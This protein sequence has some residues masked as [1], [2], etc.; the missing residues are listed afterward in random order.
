MSN[1]S[2][3]E[4][5]QLPL[6][7]FGQPADRKFPIL[8]QSD[9]DGAKHLIGNAHDPARC[10]RRII[11]I[12]RRH[13]WTV[14]KEWEDQ[15]EHA[16]MGKSA[17]NL[18]EA[19]EQLEQEIQD[20][21]DE[22]IGNILQKAL[23]AFQRRGLRKGAVPAKS[24]VAAKVPRS[25]KH[26]SIGDNPADDEDEITE[27]GDAGGVSEE[28]IQN[29]HELD[30]GD[31]KRV[32]AARTRG[33]GG[34]KALPDSLPV[35]RAKSMA[36]DNTAYNERVADDDE[37]YDDDDE[38]DEEEHEAPKKIKK[39]IAPPPAGQAPPPPPPP[40]V[41]ADPEAEEEEEDP[42]ADEDGSGEEEE[43]PTDGEAAAAMA[44]MAK[45]GRVARKSQG[46]ETFRAAVDEFPGIEDYLDASDVLQHVVKSLT[47]ALRVM[48]Q[49][50]ERRL[51]DL[52]QGVAKSLQD[53]L[54]KALDAGLEPFAAAQSALL[55]SQQY[56]V[57]ALAAAP[58]PVAQQPM[59]G[60]YWNPLVAAQL[61]PAAAKT[62]PDAV[63]GISKDEMN[64]RL[65]KAMRENNQEAVNLLGR[66]DRLGPDGVF[67][68]MS[69]G[70]KTALK[71][72]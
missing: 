70:L 16:T 53:Q 67:G 61:T 27:L 10:K 34:E 69:D 4:R 64:A 42:N 30:A 45:K 32:T 54:T 35:K 36:K 60:A 57:K 59:T 37:D 55:Q 9:V 26:G 8:D 66:L 6:S 17:Q 47:K 18:T 29:D 13:G 33:K 24:A 7:V 51:V 39:A 52:Q 28:S 71:L 11:R 20:V 22:Q 68:L 1:L 19:A 43:D 2:P 31:G 25:A 50:Q 48:D 65:S 46:A 38:D 40:A 58:A 3:E 49:Q 21:D 12:A 23:S 44:A 41:E 56:L 15:E 72:G 62:T 5:D 14:P 63:A